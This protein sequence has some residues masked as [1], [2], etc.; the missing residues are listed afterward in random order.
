M[1]PCTDPA[2][3]PTVAIY[4][5]LQRMGFEV[6]YDNRATDLTKEGMLKGIERAA[7][8]LLFLSQGVLQRPYCQMEIRHALALKKPMVLLH[9][10]DARHGSFDFRAGRAEA[11]ADFRDLLDNCESLP[12]RRRGY[13]R[14]GMLK[15]VVERSGFA[16]LYESS[17]RQRA[18][19][20]ADVLAA[21]PGAA[22]HF[23]LD[24]LFERPVQ[25]EVIKLL[26]LPKK[27]E[28]F[29]SCVLI[30]GMGGTGKT[31]TAVAAVQERAIAGIT[32]K[33]E[34]A[35]DDHERQGMLVGAMAEKLR[36][37]VVLDDPWVPEQ[38]R[39]L[40]PID[41]SQTEHRLLATTRVRDLVPKATRVE[42]PLMEKDEAVALLLELANVE[43]A[44][45]LK[46]NSS[47]AWPPPAAYTIAAECGLL[48][49]TL[50]IAAQVVRSWGE[51][52]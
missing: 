32:M 41:G 36:A 27:H 13:E 49:V 3:L 6:W 52:W 18:G 51:G 48:P 35:K 43:E 17:Q 19:S 14:D 10:S 28:L 9:E 46:G 7:A 40:N 5:E 25:A 50:T 34:G 16:Q 39:F 2:C 4:L 29:A 26:L 33:G 20:K 23:T 44:S 38:V 45:Y 1:R 8:F 30:H 22:S 15:V 12:F 21:V 42:L 37:L 11:P 31:V 24:A 47:S